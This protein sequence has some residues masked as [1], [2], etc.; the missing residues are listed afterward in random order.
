MAKSHEK[1]TKRRSGVS[2]RLIAL[3]CVPLLAA[4]LPRT[5]YMPR[6]YQRALRDS[7]RSRNGRPGPKYW[8]N[9]AHYRIS[10]TASPPNR[11]I[12]GLE[13]VSYANNSPDTLHHL[14]FKLLMNVH[15]AGAPEAPVNRNPTSR[16]V[17]T[18]T[19]SQ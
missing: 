19:P 14:V 6:T 16:R 13:H 4:Q 9:H 18:S 7:T 15:R 2:R 1:R 10:V 5:L 11:T 17:S 12:H 3:L 8:E